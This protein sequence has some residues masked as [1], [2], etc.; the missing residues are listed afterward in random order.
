MS[1]TVWILAQMGKEDLICTPCHDGYAEFMERIQNDML[2]NE[3]SLRYIIESIRHS[4]EFQ[5]SLLYSSL[6]RNQDLIP[7]F[8]YDPDEKYLKIDELTQLY[9]EE[10]MKMFSFNELDELVL[11]LQSLKGASWISL[12]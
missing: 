3:N 12:H 5:N 1:L 10:L 6:E 8:V 7:D 11:F 9:G 4:V 2:I